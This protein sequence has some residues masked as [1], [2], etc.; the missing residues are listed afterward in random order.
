MI[1]E[2][3]LG[4]VGKRSNCRAANFFFFFFF[5]VGGMGGSV[6]G[7]ILGNGESRESMAQMRDESSWRRCDLVAQKASFRGTLEERSLQFSG[8]GNFQKFDVA[9]WRIRYCVV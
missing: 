5:A 7:E 1:L 4:V 2:I 3:I 8:I 9:R 6:T